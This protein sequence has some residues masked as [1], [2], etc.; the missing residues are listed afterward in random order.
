MNILAVGKFY[1]EG[2]AEAAALGAPYS[3]LH[4]N[5]EQPITI[6][7]GSNTLTG[8]DPDA[9]LRAVADVLDH[10][11]KAGRVPERWDGQAAERIADDLI[12]WIQIATTIAT[13]RA[14][15]VSRS[16]TGL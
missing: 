15:A 4:V 6:E 9:I 1:T 11:G 7:Q 13:A 5:T 14:S 10:G 8:T 3:A 16:A 12:D 2:F